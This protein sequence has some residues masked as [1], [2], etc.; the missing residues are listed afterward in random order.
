M[1][2]SPNGKS[3]ASGYYKVLYD[4]QPGQRDFDLYRFFLFRVLAL[5]SF[6]GVH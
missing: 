2:Y 1:R 6:Q 3:L 4:A 5:D